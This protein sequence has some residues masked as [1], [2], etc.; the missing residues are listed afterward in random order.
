MSKNSLAVLIVIVA[1][2]GCSSTIE[3]DA[4]F[5]VQLDN[6]T[7]CNLIVLYPFKN[8]DSTEINRTGT[9]ERRESKIFTMAGS[10][11]IEYNGKSSRFDVRPKDCYWETCVFKIDSI[12][13]GVN[14][15]KR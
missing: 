9:L 8:A 5:S 4:N 15:E 6:L 13:I 1:A 14:V 11:S 12:A 2:Y 7:D 3:D 10:F